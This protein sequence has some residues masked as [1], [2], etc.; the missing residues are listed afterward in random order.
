M[1]YIVVAFFLLSISSFWSCR[2]EPL[3]IDIPIQEPQ[4]VV[5]SQIIPGEFMT[6]SLTKTISALDFNEE[7]GDSLNQNLLNNLLETGATVTI[8]YRDITDTLFEIP[9]NTTGMGTGV[10]VSLQT[11]QY[12]NEEYTLNV[13]TKEGKKL[14]SKSLM[15]PLVE[16]E[17]VTPIIKRTSDD[18]LVTV[19]FK[20]VDLPE[21]NWYMLNFYTNGDG[22]QQGIDLN[23]FFNSGS[24]VLKK[25]ELLDDILFNGTTY[26]GT[27]EL[28]NVSP[29]DSLVVTLS[30]INETYYRFL[31][32]RK[33]SSNFFTELTKEPISSPTNIEGGLG[34]FNT[35]FPD[36]KFY[37]LNEY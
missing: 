33:T 4:V 1:R 7:E 18:T 35:H 10:Y 28:P 27:V 2:P 34:F 23:S 37:D 21:D 11:P 26:E 20:I 12:I 14:S 31:D 8:S 24:N 9:S 15:L 5:F 29:T 30:N 22:G 19:N 3:E 17:E 32:I 6:I 25:T 16:F 13:T 36:L